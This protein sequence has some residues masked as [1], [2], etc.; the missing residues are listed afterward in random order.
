MREWRS[1]PEN[2]ERNKEYLR[3]WRSHPENRELKNEWQ[4]IKYSNDAEYRA[5]DN[6][7]GRSRNIKRKEKKKKLLY[8]RQHGLCGLCMEEDT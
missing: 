1:D 6:A 3:E 8:E 7:R 4:R 5:K 2:R